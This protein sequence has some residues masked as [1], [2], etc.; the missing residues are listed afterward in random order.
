MPQKKREDRESASFMHASNQ[1]LIP[2]VVTDALT[3]RHH[4]ASVMAVIGR[5]FRLLSKITHLDQLELLLRVMLPRQSN[6]I[7]RH[8]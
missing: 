6:I 5:T 2:Y 8:A 3:C 7:H 1:Y 4:T